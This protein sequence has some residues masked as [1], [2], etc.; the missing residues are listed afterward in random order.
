M[1]EICGE[2][3]WLVD[4]HQ[5]AAIAD[6]LTCLLAEPERREHLRQLGLARAQ[7]YSWERTARETAVVYE[8]VLN[9]NHR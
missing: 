6:G 7:Q 1:A 3:A 2:A 8:T 9:G 5:V 4:P